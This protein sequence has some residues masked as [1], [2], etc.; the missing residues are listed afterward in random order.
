MLCSQCLIQHLV[1]TPIIII[2]ITENDCC[3]VVCIHFPWFYL[4]TISCLLLS[5]DFIL[6]FYAS[7]GMSFD[8]SELLYEVMTFTLNFIFL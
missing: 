7:S 2:L 5:F 4:V 6:S 8:H 3:I 1:H